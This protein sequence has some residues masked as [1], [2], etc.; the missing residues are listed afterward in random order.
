MYAVYMYL[1][2]YVQ[3]DLSH[4]FVT[5]SFDWTIK[6]WSSRLQNEMQLTV[7]TIRQAIHS[8]YKLAE[9]IL[10]IHRYICTTVQQVHS[11]TAILWLI[12]YLFSSP[13][14]E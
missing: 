12:Y 2:M 5:S 10:V 3:V 7:R 14:A 11:P 6:L 9:A 8:L 13:S 1:Y 4:L